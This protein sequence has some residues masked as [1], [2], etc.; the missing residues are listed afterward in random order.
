MAWELATFSTDLLREPE[1]IKGVD[2]EIVPPGSSVRVTHVLD[3]VE[4]P[5]RRARR[6][7]PRG[8]RR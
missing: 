5:A 1:A 3:A 8:S 4:P 2:V 7:P 6:V